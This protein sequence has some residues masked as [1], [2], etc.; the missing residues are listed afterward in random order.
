[1][2]RLLKTSDVDLTMYQKH[3]DNLRHRFLG[4]VLTDSHSVGLAWGQRTCFSIKFLGDAGAAGPRAT[5]GE[6]LAESF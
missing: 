4:P 2:N 5:L 3:M 1:M 6:S